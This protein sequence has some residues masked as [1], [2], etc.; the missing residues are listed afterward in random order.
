MTDETPAPEP[1]GL[2]DK[3]SA[4]P[5]AGKD[6]VK[7]LLSRVT[8]LGALGTLFSFGFNVAGVQEK[9]CSFSAPQP[10][11]SDSCGALGLGSK[12]PREERLAW[13]ALPA[14]DCKAIEGFV[15]K[16]K[17]TAYLEKATHSLEL[18]RSVR[19]VSV[20][21]YARDGV[22]LAYVRQA[23]RPLGSRT[24]AEASARQLAETDAATA[25][26]APDGPEERRVRVELIEFTPQCTE[27]PGTGFMCGAD[28]R[29]RCHMTGRRLIEWCGTGAPR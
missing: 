17:D 7:T 2:R 18:R 9:A 13:A 1:S 5:D 6:K 24:A 4:L 22:N 20:T 29:P 15:S 25:A 26:C 3:L 14:G 28:Y 16:Y 11:L 23:P 10:L 19:A 21:N 27:I 8:L 12:P